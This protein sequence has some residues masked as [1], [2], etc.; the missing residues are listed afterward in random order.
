M[1]IIITSFTIGSICRSNFGAN[2]CSTNEYSESQSS[3]D[4]GNI[5]LL[6]RL[7]VGGTADEGLGVARDLTLLGR[8]PIRGGE[9][10]VVQEAGSGGHF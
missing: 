7:L 10:M 8:Q 4:K 5:V 2:G 9:C 1:L 6:W 3:G